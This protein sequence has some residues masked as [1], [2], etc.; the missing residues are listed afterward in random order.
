M[1]SLAIRMLADLHSSQSRLFSGR[2]CTCV[3]EYLVTWWDKAIV[4]EIIDCSSINILKKGKKNSV[5]LARERTVSPK[6]PPFVC[7][8]SAV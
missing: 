4:H 6:R 7:E 2:M 8:F 5:A 1:F 3:S